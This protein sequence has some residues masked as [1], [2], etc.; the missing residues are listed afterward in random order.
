[1]KKVPYRLLFL[2]AAYFLLFIVLMIFG[3]NALALFFN[4]VTGNVS[5]SHL[6]LFFGLVTDSLV[7]L[8]ALVFIL[9]FF[10]LLLPQWK[11]VRPILLSLSLSLTLTNF[12]VTSLKSFSQRLRP[13]QLL[14]EKI[15]T[16]GTNLPL[17]SSMPS[18]HSGNSMAI[19]ASLGFKVKKLWLAIILFLWAFLLAFTRLFFGF[20][21][22][23]DVIVGGI[24]GLLMVY[25][26]QLLIEWLYQEKKISLKG[27]WILFL[28]M[29]LVWGISQISR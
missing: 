14:G 3:D 19:A 9:T 5:N 23:S 8:G 4:P 16:F 13:Y 6:A 27:E 17:D 2:C 22:L 24:I 28:A 29:V 1:M 12:F 7:Y 11:K 20:H 18:A 21:F 25:S 15:N 10:S 26:S